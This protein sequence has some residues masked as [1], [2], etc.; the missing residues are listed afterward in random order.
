MA[1][2]KLTDL[3]VAL[4]GGAPATDT[5]TNGA[6]NAAFMQKAQDRLFSS[7]G[8]ISSADTGIEKAFADARGGLTRAGE[9]TTERLESQFGR[10]RVGEVGEARDRFQ[11]FAESR[12]GFGGQMTAFRRLVETT[13]KNLN[14]IESRKQEAILA[15]DSATATA[16]ANL[17]VQEIQ[18][19][20]QA[21]QQTFS[22]ML[23]I[24]QL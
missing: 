12:T 8:V 7:A 6:D 24:A 4:A 1:T 21:Q 23:G 11:N 13:D 9:A 16:L 17:Q 22:N 10:E 2:K 20:Q 18:F 5:T 15:G 19:K 14:D 3:S